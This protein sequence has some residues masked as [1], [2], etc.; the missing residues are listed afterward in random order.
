[1]KNSIGKSSRKLLVATTI[2]CGLAFLAFKFFEPVFV[3]NSGWKEF[4]T[5][6]APTKTEFFGE[7]WRNQA[8]AAN[9]IVAEYYPEVNAPALSIA[10]SVDGTMVWRSTTGYADL[11]NRTPNSFDHAFRIGS[12]SKPITSVVIGTLVDQG[13]LKLDSK[14]RNFDPSLNENLNEV[15]LEQVLSHRA[16]IRNYGTCLCFPIW[17]HQNTKQYRSL[18]KSVSGIEG[19]KL[20][21]QPGARYSY[22]SL[23]YNLAGLAAEKSV[24]QS[25]S[26]IVQAN[27]LAPLK[28]NHTY[29]EDT[30]TEQLN[31]SMA[32]PYEVEN[33]RYKPTF[34]VNQS[35][36]WPSGGFL[37]TPSDM[38]KLGNAMLG[39]HL[40]SK[41]IRSK[42]LTIP[43]AGREHGG[44]VYALGWRVHDWQINSER[45]LK[46]FNHHGV[47]VGGISA[48]V[49]FPE[50]RMVVS[51]MINKNGTN[52]NALTKIVGPLASI[53]IQTK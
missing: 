31:A 37:S 7:K 27:V 9:K 30:T 16:G 15:T 42:L 33:N 21:S 50:E 52:P 3:Y 20:L 23:G 40:L 8:D 17:E 36:R 25:F 14:I 47:S 28:M 51:V 49:V 22:T 18:R 6:T 46:S 32:K 5:H 35:I 39:D 4:E 34:E 53:F 24:K 11:E 2:F 10:V 45:T 41:E 48:F 13:K 38:I 26:E 12:T 29:L 1:M 43:Q 44:D 19:S